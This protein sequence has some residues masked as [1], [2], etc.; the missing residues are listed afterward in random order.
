[1]YSSALVAAGPSPATARA[2]LAYLETPEAQAIFL[3]SGV[4]RRR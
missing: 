4:V 3:A 1:M 2:F